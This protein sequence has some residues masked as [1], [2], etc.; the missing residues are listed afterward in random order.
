M[1]NLPR[2]MIA[3]THSGVGKTTVALA[4]M[5]MLDKYGLRVQPFK[6]GPDYI[7][8]GFHQIATG[9][10][11]RNLDTFFLGAEGVQEVFTRSARS[12]DISV[13]EGVMGLYD[14]IGAGDDGSSARVAQI[15]NCPVI[16]VLDARSMAHSAAA[17]VWGFANFPGG[18]PLAGVIINRAGSPRHLKILTE[19]IEAKTGIPV[20]GG[21]LREQDL[22]LP[23]RHLGLVPS[24]ENERIVSVIDKMAHRI[25]EAIP[26]ER[27]LSLAR[28]APA[29][30]RLE[31]IFAV[32]EQAKIQLGV[33]RDKAFNFY[34][35]DGLDLLEQM[36]AEIY[37][38]SALN[39]SKL[40]EGLDGLYIG[41]GFPEMFIEQLADNHTF[42]E[43]LGRRAAVGMPV[44]A[45]C[46][47]LMYLCRSITD[48]SGREYQGAGIIPASCK[49]GHKR[50]ALGY[51]SATAIS[52]NI[53]VDQ[54]AKL[55]GHEFHYSKIND[56]EL[57]GAYMLQ[58][59]GDGSCHRDGHAE[60]NIL[61]TYL[62][63]HF[64]GSTAAARGFL[65]SCAAYRQYRRIQN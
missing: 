54:G 63:I 36:G 42:I 38:C 6:V 2:I 4:V 25:M 31:K 62:H 7:D 22:H 45:E 40:P 19:A 49:M 43:D 52:S 23:E 61:A 1:L 17:L 12:A 41:G 58:K 35:Q 56:D 44:Y 5:A 48:F 3:G 55:R 37:T 57:N 16:L 32:D 53:L 10:V 47:G 46:G 30:N 9:C 51:V 11:S 8:P 33:V 20:L 13:I 28:R 15:L 34:Y 14:G 27:I 59:P 24:L 60:S 26:A 39:D 18:V 29:L 21:I 64:A 65:R 50:A